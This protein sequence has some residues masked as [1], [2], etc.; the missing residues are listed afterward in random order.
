VQHAPLWQRYYASRSAIWQELHT[1]GVH[2]STVGNEQWLFLGSAHSDVAALCAPSSCPGFDSALTAV[3]TSGLA[4]S[5]LSDWGSFA[6]NNHTPQTCLRFSTSVAPW[7]Q[8]NDNVKGPMGRQ[9]TLVV[10]LCRVAAGHMADLPLGSHATVPPGF[11]SACSGCADGRGGPPNLNPRW[12]PLA[13]VLVPR[14]AQ[15]Y[16]AYLLSFKPG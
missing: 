12:R 10:L 13:E 3:A 7:V 5:G 16:P 15:V 8:A 1:A 4:P 11:H 2:A 6:N 14:A 9:A